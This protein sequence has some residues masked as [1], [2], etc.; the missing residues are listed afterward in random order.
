MKEGKKLIK[1]I[2]LKYADPISSIDL[3]DN[4][5]L[6]GTM[7]GTTQFYTIEQNQLKTLSEI[8][9]EFISGV[10]IYNNKLYICI[11]DFKII[12][13]EIDDKNDNE[14][15][16]EYLEIKNYTDS[17][18]DIDIE[19]TNNCENCLTILSD[20]YLIRT[21]IDFP[22]EANAEPIIKET[23]FSI[24]NIIKKNENNE[25]NEEIKGETKMSNYCVPFD[26]D[27]ENYI[28]IDFIK[29]NQRFFKIYDVN[30][31][32]ETEIEI[33][34]KFENEKFG[35]ISHLKVV[36][37]DLLF[38]VRNYNICELRNYKLEL[39]KT[40]NIKSKEILAFDL[41]FDEDNTNQGKDNNNNTNENE[42]Q[43]IETDKE[44]LYIGILDIDCNIYLYNYKEDTCKLLFNLEN[45]DLGIDEDIK[46]Q[47]FFLFGFPYYIKITKKYVAVTSDYGCI[48]V[49]YSSL[50]K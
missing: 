32:S 35:H 23:K 5:L 9:D 40:L 2:E 16:P 25:D 4:Y 27:G 31:K 18:N 13:Y 46:G 24:K 36:K 45:D 49:D 20:N 39:N 33:E 50:L 34:K 1:F 29:E 26:F 6:F 41:L 19:H 30:S 44:L 37:K 17:N 38:I 7:L 14:K 43:D 3:T 15:I 8:Q 22:A 28:Y 10:K 42:N 21:F 48:L 11:G 12:V 47:R